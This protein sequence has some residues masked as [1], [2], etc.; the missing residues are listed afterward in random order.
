MGFGCTVMARNIVSSSLIVYGVRKDCWGPRASIAYYLH[1]ILLV[2]IFTIHRGSEFPSFLLHTSKGGHIYVRT[3]VENRNIDILDESM[4]VNATADIND[5]EANDI[6]SLQGGATMSGHTYGA[7]FMKAVADDM[8]KAKDKELKEEK[9]K[10]KE[11]K[12]T[13]PVEVV[14]IDPLHQGT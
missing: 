7:G 13:E 10:D 12:T 14:V 2:Y 11:N 4:A 3:K 5:E 8:R 1:L 6:F 9:E